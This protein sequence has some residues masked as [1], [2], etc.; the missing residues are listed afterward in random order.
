MNAPRLPGT[1]PPATWH[2]DER[3]FRNYAA[4]LLDRAAEAAVEAHLIRCAAC[5][6]L[7]AS[8][9]PLTTSDPAWESVAVKIATPRRRIPP[10]LL[11]LVGLR[12][13]DVVVL[14]ASG[15][16]HLP[17][18][19]AVTVTLVLAAVLGGLPSHQQHAFLM[20]TVPLLPTMLIA[21]SYDLTDGLR[22]LVETTPYDKFRLALLRTG[23]AVVTA[24]PP[25]AIMAVLMP[26]FSVR[27]G[28]WLLPVLALVVVAL[29][30]LTRLSGLVTLLVVCGG[31]WTTVAALNL[32]DSMSLAYRPAAQL[33]VAAFVLLAGVALCRRLSP[34]FSPTRI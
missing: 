1:Q 6:T 17:W 31:W 16:I 7:V 34:S 19:A 30:L 15:G 3:L 10:R 13:S 25:V 32:T 23:L 9:E 18:V 14:R 5:R 12:E 11:R 8:T 20:G 24:I 29:H 4:G 22:P 26:E 2:A 21:L 33:V 28:G 27:A